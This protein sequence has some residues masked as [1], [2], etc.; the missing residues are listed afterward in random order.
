MILAFVGMEG[1]M[2]RLRGP[3]AMA[4]PHRSNAKGRPLTP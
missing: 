3:G 1:A 4:H 2:R